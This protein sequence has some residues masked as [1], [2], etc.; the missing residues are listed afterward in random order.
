MATKKKMLQAA[1]G[2]AG[3][4]GL[5][6]TEV[7]SNYLYA[8]TSGNITVSNGIDLLNEG[9][10]IWVKKR[11]SAEDHYII[12]TERGVN[13]NLASNTAAA[14]TGVTTISSFYNNGFLVRANLSTLDQDYVSW[15]FRKAP[16]FL[17][18]VTYTGDGTNNRSIAH[19][20]GS[21]PGC[22]ITKMTSGSKDWKVYHRGLDASNPENYKIH[23]NGTDARSDGS[24]LFDAP[25]DTHFI[26]D[27]NDDVNGNGDTY[28]AYLFA[29]NDGDGGFGPSGDQDIIKCGRYTGNNSTNG[30]E[31]DLGFEPQWI[32][33]KNATASQSWWMHDTMRGLVTSSNGSD[34]ARLKANAT[35][36]E[37]TSNHLH[38]T[39]TGFKITSSASGVN[40]SADYIYVA[41]R[42]GPLAPPESATEVFDIQFNGGNDPSK[43]PIYQSGFVTDMAIVGY[44]TGGSVNYPYTGNRLMGIQTLETHNADAEESGGTSF[45]WDFMNGFIDGVPSVITDTQIAWMW[46]RAPNYFD[47]VAYT[48]EGAN[49]VI[50]HNLDAI[51]EMVWVK[52]RGRAQNW[53]V[54]HKDLENNGD[55]ASECRLFLNNTSAVSS[56]AV[57]WGT[58]TD[59]TFT[60]TVQNFQTNYLNDTY[61]AYLFAT[62]AGVSKVGSYTGNGSSQ[63][64]DCGFTSGA[65]FILVKRTDS[66]G[67]WYIWDSVRGIGAGNDP[68]LSLNTT[69]AEVTSDDSTDPASSGFIV[70]Q[71]S[72]TNINVSSASYIFYAI[73]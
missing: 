4:A 2:Q 46:K 23:L 29:H 51:P 61:I 34:D 7:F 67:D 3:G 62:L 73:A 58:H 1:A 24:T 9:G 15:T 40:E 18:V 47:V 69:A 6:V 66:T 63:T 39:P 28:V 44:R 56:G 27:S 42:R 5:D 53:N 35:T 50:N 25:T 55:P 71:V 38:V 20:L 11:T 48:G 70:N 32:M 45:Q 41:I 14:Q 16:K 21:V 68:H 36:A 17:D 13:K 57:F 30:P 60:M 31:I 8:G 64:I 26:L 33:I 22:I 59:T 49:T 54:Y 37:D 43:A 72:A 19:N 12:D 52:N 10:L 65:R